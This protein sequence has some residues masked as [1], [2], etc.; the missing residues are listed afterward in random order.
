MS[1]VQEQSEFLLDVAKLILFAHTKGWRVTGGELFRTLEQQKIHYNA[2]RSKTM[3][4]YHLKRLAIDLNFFKPKSVMP[5]YNKSELEMFGQY[6]EDLNPVNRWGGNF[7][8]D[9]EDTP[10]F[11][12][13]YKKES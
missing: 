1:L 2:G 8:A 11:E 4:S 6:W 12:R 7:S 13:R 10:H 9:F 5:T 3:D